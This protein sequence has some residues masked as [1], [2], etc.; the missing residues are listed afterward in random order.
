MIV[1]KYKIT[2]QWNKYNDNGIPS[3][4]IPWEKVQKAW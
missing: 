2:N 4:P 3:M 1:T